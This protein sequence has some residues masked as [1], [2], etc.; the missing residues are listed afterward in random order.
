MRLVGGRLHKRGA[1]IGGCLCSLRRWQQ[2]PVT[3]RGEPRIGIDQPV[4]G[5]ADA[6]PDGEYAE[7]LGEVVDTHLGAQLVKI[8]PVDKAEG[9]RARAVEKEAAAVLG[10]SFGDDEVHDDL[11]LGSKQGGEGR[12]LRRHLA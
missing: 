12:A 9:K 1:E 5:R 10:R 3:E 8:Q 2:D 4:L 7:R 6:H 11:A